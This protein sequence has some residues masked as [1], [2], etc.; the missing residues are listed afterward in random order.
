MSQNHIFGS[1]YSTHSVLSKASYLTW[2]CWL[3]GHVSPIWKATLTAGSPHP[4]QLP[5]A[6]GS[7]RFCQNIYCLSHSTQGG[8]SFKAR[9][10]EVLSYP[11]HWGFLLLTALPFW[12]FLLWVGWPTF[13]QALVYHLPPQARPT[14]CVSIGGPWDQE[15]LICLGRAGSSAFVYIPS[16]AAESWA[17]SAQGQTGPITALH[18]LGLHVAIILEHISLVCAKPLIPPHVQSPQDHGCFL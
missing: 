15:G 11:G 2:D 12:P 9:P 3:E 17:C 7:S 1:V 8:D 18:C 16:W 5:D 14:L 4:S 10:S 13:H 6:P